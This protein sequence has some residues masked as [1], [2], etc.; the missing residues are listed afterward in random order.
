VACFS[1]TIRNEGFFGLYKGMASPL[2][3]GPILNAVVFSTYEQAKRFLEGP[4]DH[5]CVPVDSR[6][7]LAH[8]GVAGGYAG[9][10]NCFI[11]A[12]VELLKSRLQ[13][14]YSDGKYKGPFDCAKRILQTEGIKGIYRGMSA[15]I[16][17]DVPAYTTQFVA[18][19]F[20]KRQ[21]S[22]LSF[23]PSPVSADSNEKNGSGNGCT[24]YD[25]VSLGGL[26]MAGGIAGLIGW[27]ASY[28]QDIIKS[29]LQITEKE[30]A[31]QYRSRYKD[32]GFWECGK[33]IVAKHGWKG[34]WSG[35]SICAARAFPANAAAFLA[36]E[37]TLRFL[38]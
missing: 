27:S 33:H 31:I 7:T 32:G 30:S 14:Q 37:W 4:D 10:I 36:Y 29:N 23:S 13:I 26:L 16:L 3:S 22:T 11:I 25:N 18:Y 28:P 35:F 8:I 2:V 38:R 15:T 9:L 17:R 5:G 20:L 12:P 34:L 19:E 24:N 21:F 6:L 1:A